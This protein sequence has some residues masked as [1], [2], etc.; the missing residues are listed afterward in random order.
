VRRTETVV[1]ASAACY[2]HRIG[3]AVPAHTFTADEAVD[4]FRQA[5][6]DPRAATLLRRLARLTGIEKR[7]LACLAHQSAGHGPGSLYRPVSEQPHGPGMGARH[8]LFDPAAAELVRAATGEL[9]RDL[10]AGVGLLV[11]VTCTQA[12]SPGLERAV[13]AHTPVPRTSD[14]WN[15]GFMG[16]SAGLAGLRLIHAAAARPRAALLVTCELAS[17]H[18]QYSENLDQ[19]TANLLF[20]D[21]AA[22]VALGPRPSGVRVVDC[23]CVVLPQFADQMVWTAGDHGFALALSPELPQTLAAQLPTALESWLDGQGLA[24]GQIAHWLV[25][26]GGPQILDAVQATLELPGDALA[27][28][29]AVLREYGNMSSSTI[30]FILRAA[31]A[32]GLT[33]RCVAMAFGPGLTIELALLE[34]SRPAGG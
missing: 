8:A 5:Y 3:T 17:L 21:G 4:A 33:G 11:T 1:T 20:A 30:L 13:F 2:I 7:H 19:T 16:C 22:A 34:L 26:P 29:R 23:R 28:S 12:A 6:R 27:L 9:P 10:L 15:L 31:L 14:R 24:R 18:F 25:H 32:Q